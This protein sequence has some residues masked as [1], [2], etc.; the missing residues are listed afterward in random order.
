[1]GSPVKAYLFAGRAASAAASAQA[2]EDWYK[3][4]L[5]TGTV[6]VMLADVPSDIAGR[7]TLHDPLG[8]QIHSEYSSTPGASVQLK[9]TGLAPG[10]YYVKISPFTP[11]HG[12][13]NGQTIPQYATQPYTLTV[14]P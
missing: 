6:T 11:H 4:R 9:K 7:I 13:G 5:T 2:W 8:S 10:D 12:A 3:V 14:T 1:M